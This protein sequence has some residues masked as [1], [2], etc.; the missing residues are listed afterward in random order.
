MRILLRCDGGASLGVGHAMRSLA[1]AEAAV[2]AGHDVVVAGH[3][4]GELLLRQ[5]VTAPV[6]VLFLPAA[7]AGGDS[8]E[9]VDLV[10]RLRPDV[11]HADS[12]GAS[13]RLGE[14][15]ATTGVSDVVFSNMEDGAFG[16]RPADVVVDPTLG[17]ELSSR[18]EDGSGWL[19]RGS[20]YTPVRRRVI[21]ARRPAAGVA[22]DRGQQVARS[23]LVV[24][25]GTDPVGL[26]PAAV[27]LLSSTGLPLEVTAIAE[28]ENAERALAAARGSR[29]S[30]TVL[31]PVDD[32]A[33]LMSARDLVISAAG[34]SIWELCCL[35]VPAALVWAVDNQ[36]A[37]YDEVVAAG[38][39]VG[40]GGPELGKDAGSV[41]LLTRALT[42]PG[43]RA[44]LAA[45]GRRV[46]DGLGS[47]R[48]VRTWEMAK[49]QRLRPVSLPTPDAVA[50]V[51]RPATL[52]D[53][54]Q[55]WSWRNDP[56]TRAGS[57]SS[58][59]VPWDDHLRWLEA[60]LTR[61]DRMLL[62]VH[63]AGSA[64]GPV[65][66][67]RWD[68]VREPVG[69]RESGQPGARRGRPGGWPEWEVSITVAP[70]RRGQSLARPLLR[71][72]ETALCERTRSSGTDVSAY[73]AVVHADNGASVRLFEASG[74]VPDLPADPRGFM[75]FRKIA[76][77]P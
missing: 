20:R 65:G 55:L 13:E 75:R 29:L 44:A 32:L 77:V 5:L 50:L 12:Y 41:E 61:T 6:E 51:A 9:V 17:A 1:L 69:E 16:R 40:L 38:A 35:G 62:V 7:M 43:V 52:Q 47:W 72:A 59:E 42:H 2:A 58:A 18:P 23:V 4:E 10:Q 68:L 3:F 26:V 33:E 54:Q 39:A 19:L 66:T 34:T 70:G 36:R 67:V 15:V 27:G 24:M 60:S 57:R 30:L 63:D 37:G 25:G 22:S 73:L 74:Y 8:R 45:A 64:G 48:V 11:L 14:L 46:V 31:A 76:R 21:D 56:A 53:A 71:A 28:G 49:R